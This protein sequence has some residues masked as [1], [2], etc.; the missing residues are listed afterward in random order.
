MS[1]APHLSY[2]GFRLFSPAPVLRPYIRN[3][4]LI[5]SQS[6]LTIRH[7]EFLH[8]EGGFG[9]IFNFGDRFVCDGKLIEKKYSLDGANSRSRRIQFYGNVEA[10][11]IRFYTGGAYP[12]LQIPLYELADE[13]LLLDDLALHLIDSL[14]E[15]IINTADIAGKIHLLET[16]LIAR[17]NRSEA[18]LSDLIQPALRLIHNQDEALSIKTIADDLFISQRQLER[19]FKTQ[20][21]I[22]PKHYSR[23]QRIEQ[24]RQYLKIQATNAEASIGIAPGYYDQSHFIREFKANVGMTPLQYKERQLKRLSS[25]SNS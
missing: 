16:W 21:G 5:Q 9:M 11:G 2:L 24:A 14:Y 7:E 19:I 17:L 18:S 25:Q 1:T 3:Y 10:I 8:P 6:K 20:V 4:W 13:F 12:F 22:S 23:L 15:Q